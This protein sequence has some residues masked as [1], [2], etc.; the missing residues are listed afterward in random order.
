MSADGQSFLL[1]LCGKSKKKFLLASIKIFTNSK[2]P[3]R[4]TLQEACSGFEKTTHEFQ[5]CSESR[6]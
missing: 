1:S 6:L 3:S 2:N 4:N 5:N